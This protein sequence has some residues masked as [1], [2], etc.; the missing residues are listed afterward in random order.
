MRPPR[1]HEQALLASSEALLQ[2][3]LRETGAPPMARLDVLE[4]LA[5][6]EGGWPLKD[7]RSSFA[8]P[9][10]L[11]TEEAQL[12]ADKLADVLASAR[13]PVPL[14]IAALAR[15]D[16]HKGEQRKAG[17]YYTDFRLAQYL[18][19]P[20]A[21]SLVPG[22]RVIDPSAGSGMLL[23][24]LTIA[25]AHGDADAADSFVADSVCAADLSPGALRATRA[26]LASLVSGMEPLLRLDSRLVV[27][28]SLTRS[29]GEWES[30]APG[31]FSAVIGNPPWEK[32]KISRHELL[33]SSGV[34]RH[35][36]S[37]YRNLD[38]HSYNAERRKMLAYADE[39]SA[40]TH[41]QGT[42]EAD[43]YKLFLELAARLLRP[44]GQLS[45]LLPAGLIRSQGTQRLR[46]F[47][48]AHTERLSLT[49]LENRA[50]FFSIDTRFK[51]IA[52]H[53]QLGGAG[54]SE[55]L[56]LKH[57][58]GTPEGLVDTGVVQISR[59]AL[60]RIRP[61]LTI[62]EVRST[63]EWEI[64]SLMST[65]GDTLASPEWKHVYARE[66]D[67]TNDRSEF[68]FAPSAEMLPLV[69]GRM[70]HQH[71]V[72][73]KA[74]VSG[75]GRAAV[76]KPLAAA[77]AH[78]AP[79]FW[80]PEKSLRVTTLARTQ[81]GRAGFCDVTGQTNERTLLAAFVPPGVVCGNKVPTLMFQ[82]P[83]R[84]GED[85]ALLW[86]ALANSLPVDWA[87]RRVVTTSMNY[88]LL[89]SIPLPPLRDNT[90]VDTLLRNARFLA[91]AEVSAGLDPWAVAQAR[92][93]IDCLVSELFELAVS[94]V[95]R[96]FED[97]PLLDRGQP[98]LTGETRSTVT[99][100]L[101]LATFT[102][103]A[104]PETSRWDT[105][106]QAARSLGAI[107]YV[108]ADYADTG[109]SAVGSGLRSSRGRP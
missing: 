11:T 23:A 64:F 41:L 35:Y 67:M 89:R 12:W 76:W 86:T 65:G 69:E 80:Y 49:V 79:Q 92:A 45:L 38:E 54:R 96:L 40:S 36:G 61:D 62:P 75:S 20:L 84:T 82:C 16:L 5:A 9:R 50:R 2:R 58:A 78:V 15:P 21:S 71:R 32:L 107:P 94:D 101:V 77:R 60:R 53:A 3:A 34:E 73:A 31:G 66:V 18:A 51:F 103:R 44:G 74:Y 1:T 8:A 13:V 104:G 29:S 26:A 39:L 81:V 87:A 55:P 48:I 52:V 46:E 22:D 102:R 33:A 57:A 105:R 14:A 88:F 93:D 42:G 24:A 27:G 37:S 70:V 43:L 68:T 56:I 90:H 97:F 59:T 106:L 17:A 47:L 100:D 109:S 63:H 7:Y 6:Q 83:G 30:L 108:P 25:I 10:F 4:G 98:T 72:M 19:A 91:T 95:E 28:D 85:A 99:R